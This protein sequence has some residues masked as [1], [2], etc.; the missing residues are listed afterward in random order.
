LETALNRACRFHPSVSANRRQ[1]ATLQK[2][3]RFDTALS[4]LINVYLFI[5][6]VFFAFCHVGNSFTALAV[7][8]VR[9]HVFVSALSITYRRRKNR[10]ND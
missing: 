1:Q 5:A 10:G 4:A 3:G 7:A 2:Q 6:T 9:A 8:R